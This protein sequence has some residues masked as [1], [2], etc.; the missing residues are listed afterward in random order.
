MGLYTRPSRFLKVRLTRRGARWAIGPRWLR[1]HVGA[2]GPRR[3][4]RRWPSVVVPAAA[5]DAGRHHRERPAGYGWRSA[6]L[7]VP[8]AAPAAECHPQAG[9]LHPADERTPSI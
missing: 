5:A 2:G 8:A 1:L 6:L 7:S 4:D 3:L 9:Q